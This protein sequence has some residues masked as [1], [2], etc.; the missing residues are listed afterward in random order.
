MKNP[1]PVYL[2]FIGLLM[3][4][5]SFLFKAENYSPYVDVDFNKTGAVFEMTSVEYRPVGKDSV[6]II[7]F[8]RYMVLLN[9]RVHID[10]IKNY[11]GPKWYYKLYGK[12]Q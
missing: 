6:D 10:Q 8:N 2:Y 5:C 3:T 4:G 12:K 1:R 7:A 11:E 9:A